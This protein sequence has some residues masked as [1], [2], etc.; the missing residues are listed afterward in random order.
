MIMVNMIMVMAM[1]GADSCDNNYG[2]D[3]DENDDN[4][5]PNFVTF[6]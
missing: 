1:F 4:G 3:N 6:L 5:I 2:N